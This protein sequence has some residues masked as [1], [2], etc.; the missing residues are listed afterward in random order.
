MEVL[1]PEPTTPE[2]VTVTSP[3][4]SEPTDPAPS[5]LASRLEELA[6]RA[7]AMQGPAGSPSHASAPM[8]APKA[9]EMPTP[10]AGP[11]M[12]T[13]MPADSSTLPLILPGRAPVRPVAEVVEPQAGPAVAARPQPEERPIVE[14]RARTLPAA[15]SARRVNT[16]PEPEVASIPAMGVP[17]G[18]VATATAAPAAPTK[19]SLRS[20]LGKPVVLELVETEPV[21]VLDSV[22][23]LFGCRATAKGALFVQ[24][25]TLGTRV[26][27]AGEFNGWRPERAPM[28]RNEGLG[29]FELRLDLPPGA[30]RYRLVI[31]GRWC[32]DAHN[33]ERVWNA[34]G[35]ADNLLRVPRRSA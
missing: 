24:P 29:V 33:P 28:V 5:R 7:R 6:R 27:I 32:T 2:V 35:E 1:A 14:T 26:Q 4:P 18:G 30:Y 11:V 12:L 8:P 20:T 17:A 31:D 21:E 15:P 10:T 19:P 22:R 23:R 34:F 3:A 25:A 13:P 16:L 9:P